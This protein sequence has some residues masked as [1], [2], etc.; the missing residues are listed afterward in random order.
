M[1]IRFFNGYYLEQTNVPVKGEVHIEDGHIV[2]AGPSTEKHISFDREINLKGRLLMPGFKNAHTHS[3][4][5]FLRSF[6]DDMK[7]ADWLEKKVF[8]YEARLSGGDA[9]A[10]TRLAVAEY[11]AGGITAAFDMYFFPEEI[12]KAA[13]S[14]GFRMVLCGAVNNFSQSPELVGEYYERLNHM[15]SLIS[16]RLGFHAEYTANQTILKKIADLAEKYEAPVFT[17]NSETAQEVQSCIERYQMTP[18]ALFEKLGLFR[19]GGGGFHS[20]YLT[21]AD[22]DIYKRNHIYAVTNP[23]SN[24]KLASGIAP[25]CAFMERGIEIA[26]GTDGPAS[27][28]ALDMFREMYLAA[29]LQKLKENDAAA[30]PA[31]AV[32][33]MAVQ[34]GA[35]VMGLDGCDR[36][37]PGKKADLIVID[38]NQPNM[39]PCHNLVKNLVYS[40]N[41][42]NVVMTMIDGRILY[43]DGQ[44]YFNESIEDIY[45]EAEERTAKIIG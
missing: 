29:V 2:Y 7:L 39:R 9:A 22:M 31:D 43:E 30:C 14:M 21:E 8:P 25:L 20:V 33:K 23:A 26:I 36:I 3:P 12:A 27:N 42:G 10:F 40:G 1:K 41:P 38:L 17:H 6:A 15:D 44:F 5:T 18:T 24:L 13:S 34:N 37:A 11:V 16:Y 35:R 28:N 4:M 32:L 45:R 19:F